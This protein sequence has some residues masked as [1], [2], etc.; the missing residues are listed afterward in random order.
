[1]SASIGT[2]ERAQLEAAL[3]V[4]QGV[5]SDDLLGAYLCGSAVSGGLRDRSDVDLL[6]VSGR[7]TTDEE[8]GL[9]IAG[10]LPLSG[11]RAAAGPARSLEVTVVD[12]SAVR[13]WQY[14]PELDFQYGDWFRADY[15]RGDVAPWASPNPD[16][17]VLLTTAL[18]ASEPLVGPELA[19][20]VDDVPR[21]DLDRAMLDG[22]PG[23]LADLEGDT[24]NVLLTLARI[25]NTLVTGKIN[26]KDVAAEWA[27]DRLPD[28]RRSGLARAQAVYASGA[29]DAWDDLRTTVDVD[30]RRIVEEARAAV[31]PSR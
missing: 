29:E 1:V 13:P 10:L 26:P 21:D 3:A 2:V 22:I 31:R 18:G 30:A 7:P 14:P 23:L 15:E 28:E 12:Q 5:L 17:A 24:A 20:L 16:L 11:S 19:V 27:L 4:V 25:W 8:K 6:V 9:V